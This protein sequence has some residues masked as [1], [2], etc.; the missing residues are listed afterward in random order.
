[1]R[2]AFGEGSD[3]EL[4]SWVRVLNLL[5]PALYPLCLSSLRNHRTV[6]PTGFS[7]EVSEF[8]SFGDTAAMAV[9]L[10]HRAAATMSSTPRSEVVPMKRRFYQQSPFLGLI[11]VGG[12]HHVL[13]KNC[14]ACCSRAGICVR[15]EMRFGVVE[16]K[17]QIVPRKLS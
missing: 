2:P 1:M 15:S 12:V 11:I 5:R 7:Q 3:V 10:L 6:A 16:L 4:R 14:V 13:P 9:S 17:R 8:I